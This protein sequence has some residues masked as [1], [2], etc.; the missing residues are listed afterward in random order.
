MPRHAGPGELVAIGAEH[1][2]VVIASANNCTYLVNYMRPRTVLI[3]F[4]IFLGF[5][6]LFG[7]PEETVFCLTCLIVY[8]QLLNP[9]GSVR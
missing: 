6:V 3:A 9:R 7:F 5:F 2:D 8:T 4:H 1:P